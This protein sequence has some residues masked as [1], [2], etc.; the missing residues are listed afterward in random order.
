MTL[1]DAQRSLALFKSDVMPA[2]SAL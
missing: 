2:L 1:A